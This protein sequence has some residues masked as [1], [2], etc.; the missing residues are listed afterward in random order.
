MIVLFSPFHRNIISIRV[1]KRTIFHQV[2][3]GHIKNFPNTV[4]DDIESAFAG[5][6][7]ESPKRKA[8]QTS[9]SKRIAQ[10]PKRVEGK[11][12]LATID[13]HQTRRHAKSHHD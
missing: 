13:V 3:E 4:N 6:P 9:S 11:I 1:W 12:D 8:Q 5:N 2:L 7:Q 10:N